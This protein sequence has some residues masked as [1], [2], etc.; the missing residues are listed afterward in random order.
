L[1][2]EARNMALEGAHQPAEHEKS[3]FMMDTS[4]LGE[5]PKE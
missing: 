4:T 5:K 1:E 3:F 2:V